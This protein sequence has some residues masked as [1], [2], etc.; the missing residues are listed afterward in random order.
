MEEIIATKYYIAFSVAWTVLSKRNIQQSRSFARLNWH[1]YRK[2]WTAVLNTYKQLS[3]LLPNKQRPFLLLMKKNYGVKEFWVQIV[4]KSVINALMFLTGKIFCL[5][6]WQW[7]TQSITWPVN[8]WRT[9][10]WLHDCDLQREGFEDQSRRFE[11]KNNPKK[12]SEACWRSNEWKVVHVYVQL[13]PK[14][15]VSIILF[16]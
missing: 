3:S 15:M 8:V 10:R 11:K 9:R 16:Q 14:Q 5:A 1:H 12:G 7:T 2:H 6:R 13:L 4:H